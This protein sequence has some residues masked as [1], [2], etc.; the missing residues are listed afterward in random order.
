MLTALDTSPVCDTDPACSSSRVQ[1]RKLAAARADGTFDKIAELGRQLQSTQAGQTLAATTGQLRKAVNMA[2]QAMF[3][4]GMGNPGTVQSRTATV[5]KQA[6][7]LAD[8]SRQVAVGVQQLT[9]QAR[10]MGIGLDDVSAYLLTMKRDATTPAMAGFYIPP[11]TLNADAVKAAAAAF[12]SP[13][14]H[15]VR[16][17][18]L[19]DLNP[20]STAAMDQVNA[21]TDVARGA[22]PNTT[23]ADASVSMAGFSV[24]LRDTR[25]Y[26][27]RDIRF[28]V[29]VTIVVVLLILVVLL[30]AL[31]APVYLIL[32]V[33]VSYLSA[34]G[35]GAVAFEFV[36]GQELHWSVP[37]LTFIILVAVGADY[38]MLLISRIR[39]ESVQG[40]RSG[41]IRTVASTGGVITAAGL[42][43]AATMFGLVFADLT[44]MVQAGFVVG[45][46]LLLDTFLVRTV[47]VPAVATLVGRANWWPARFI[48]GKPYLRM[49]VGPSA[50]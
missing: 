26:Y 8:A 31:V 23:L 22:Q 28:V 30:R 19:T 42:I 17:L 43:F 14:G 45:V 9:D 40:V 47:T 20:F 37:G 10:K 24:M 18:V 11:Q 49:T 16:Y 3:S 5:Q 33:V 29:L 27:N 48:P 36:L 13:D 12:I 38:N 46:G 4:L 7:S 15:A 34:L 41:V 35:I 6:D 25:D 21:V 50:S 2:S 1:L 39:D 44:T 32:S